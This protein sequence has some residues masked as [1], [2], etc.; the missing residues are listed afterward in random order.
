MK[1]TTDVVI[2][3]LSALPTQT[4]LSQTLCAEKA[5]LEEQRQTGQVIHYEDLELMFSDN[6]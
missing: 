2:E 5:V 1:T 6:K 3:D 4:S